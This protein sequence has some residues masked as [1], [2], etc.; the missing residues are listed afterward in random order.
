M[1]ILEVIK[2]VTK[3][4]V[5]DIENSF[6][7]MHYDYMDEK[8]FLFEGGK[9]YGLVGEHGEGGEMISAIMS[10]RIPIKEEDI[11]FDG[12]KMN[13][14]D[15]QDIGWYVG[16]QEYTK[17]LIKKEISAKK[18]LDYA[19]KKYNRYNNVDEIIEDFHLTPNRLD[20]E[21]S[22]YSGEKWRV[23][24]AIGYACRKKVFSWMNTSVFNSI[25]LSSGVFRFFKRLKSEGCIIILPTSRKENVEGFVDEVIEIVNP[26]D[27]TVISKNPYFVEHF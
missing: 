2:L 15:M 6:N 9:I 27:R 13:R 1:G 24:L 5:E 21:L 11:F 18:A 22:K 23:S 26:Q 3:H 8:T 25:L 4:R 7:E 16:K 20:Y 14:P 10:G 12:I 17:G 19:L